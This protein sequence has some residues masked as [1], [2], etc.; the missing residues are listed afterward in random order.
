MPY[1]SQLLMLA[2]L[3]LLLQAESCWY[4][5]PGGLRA[6]K[7][8]GNIIDDPKG[9][10]TGLPGNVLPGLDFIP[11]FGGSFIDGPLWVVNKISPQGLLAFDADSLPPESFVPSR[12]V[13]VPTDSDGDGVDEGTTA[14]AG[15]TVNGIRIESLDLGL[16]TAENYEEVLFFDPSNMNTDVD[17][18]LARYLVGVPASFASDDYPFLPAPGADVES[19][20]AVSTT[21]CARIGDRLL[22]AGEAVIGDD[23]VG[24]GITKSIYTSDTSGATVI[25]NRLFVSLSNHSPISAPATPIHRPGSVLVYDF[26]GGAVSPS[27]TPL[28]LPSIV[29]TEGYN[30]TDVVAYTAPDGNDY[31]LVIVS[32]PIAEVAGLYT[33]FGDSKSYIEL[34][35]ADSLEL[36]R[37][38]ELVIEGDPSDHVATISGVSAVDEA[39][40]ILYVGS[41]VDRYLYSIDLATLIDP[42]TTGTK[43]TWKDLGPR[44]EGI[45]AAGTCRGSIRGMAISDDSSEFYAVDYCAGTLVVVEANADGS[46]ANVKDEFALT[47]PINEPDPVPGDTEADLT[48]RGPT[49]IAVRPGVPGQ[50]FEGSDLFVLVTQ[51]HISPSEGL[52]CAQEVFLE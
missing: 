18:G 52:V 29:L 33:T 7:D 49:R 12:D 5:G 31:V 43:V 35:D 13:S 6:G 25:H 36:L 47:S 37:S 44:P 22:S 10:C 30:P 39:R 41:A 28:A 15:P 23:C 20:T 2:M 14:I 9:R 16:I 38:V 19:R 24:D 1:R 34:I 8:D 46:M 42:G 11:R 45:V 21:A 50:S 32:G 17:G 26:V 40:G 51:P 48:L 3:S 4:P 27:E